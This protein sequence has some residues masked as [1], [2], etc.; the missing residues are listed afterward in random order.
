MPRAIG[1]RAIARLAAMKLTI[2]SFPDG[3]PIPAVHAFGVPSPE[4]RVAFGGNRS[5][6]LAW[7]DVPEGTKSFA[8]V[9]HDPDVPSEPDDVNQEGKTVPADLPRVDF[10]HW[11]LVDV[12]ADRRELPEGIDS[13]GVTERGKPLGATPYGIRGRNDFTGWFAGDDGMSGD[14]GG[15]DGPCPPWNDSIVHRY[16]FTVYALD[17]ESI[18]LSGAFEGADVLA[19]I[20]GNVLARASCTGTYSLN[21]DVA[22][23]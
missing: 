4:A 23:R 12:P 14:Y 19:A 2:H 18:G 21:P 11:L 7:S 3:A 15:Y 17:T 10:F 16:I 5:P 13:D 6:H 1:I 8:I 9:C 20:E 22:A